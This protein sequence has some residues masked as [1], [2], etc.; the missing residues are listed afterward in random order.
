MKGIILAGAPGPFLHPTAP[1]E[2]AA[3]PGRRPQG[4]AGAGWP[5]GR[6]DAR[7]AV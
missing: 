1:G 2:P 3:L 7:R 6:N 4:S 5:R